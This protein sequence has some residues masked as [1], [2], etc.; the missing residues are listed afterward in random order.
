MRGEVAYAATRL[1]LQLGYRVVDTGDVYDNEAEVGRAIR[2]SGIPREQV[3]VITKY[4]AG[5]TYGVAG[6]VI[7]AFNTSLLHLGLGYVDTYFVHMPVGVVK[8]KKNGWIGAHADENQLHSCSGSGQPD[9]YDPSAAAERRGTVWNDMQKL[10]ASGRARQIGVANWG[11]CHL[12][13]LM[14]SADT[15]V[16]PTIYQGEWRPSYHAE[17]LRAFLK[18]HRIEHIAYGSLH[19]ARNAKAIK[20]I[21]DLRNS[22]PSTVALQWALQRGLSVIPRSRSREHL[23]INLH[24]QREPPLDAPTLAQIEQL[25]Q[26]PKPGMGYGLTS[27]VPDDRSESAVADR[28]AHLAHL[29]RCD[30]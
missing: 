24:A 18:V 30:E 28:L 11:V 25:P 3:H 13:E 27:I 16:R 14:K 19:L 23:S 7:R 2:D 1:A 21:A 6:D 9:Q 26:H 4:L 5:C 22:T 8:H 15:N 29:A 17:P 10:Y 20:R 12:E